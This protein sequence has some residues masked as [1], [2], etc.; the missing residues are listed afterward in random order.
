MNNSGVE[1]DGG[2]GVVRKQQ[3]CFCFVCHLLPTIAILLISFTQ[4]V[5][6]G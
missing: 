2:S 6:T 3:V 4:N 1:V 5:F